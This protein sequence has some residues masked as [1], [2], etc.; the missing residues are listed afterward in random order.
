MKN[1]LTGFKYLPLPMLTAALLLPASADAVEFSISGQLS[2][3]I[4]DVDNGEESGL[5]H[6]DNSVSGTRWR[7]AGKG[8]L[9][10]GMTAG[11]LYENQLQS[12][13]SSEVTAAS[14]DSDGVGGNVGGGDYFSLRFANVWL[15]G[16][17]GKVT[18][19]QGS[20]AADGT[21]EVDQSGTTVIQYVGSSADLLGSMEYGT[22][23]VTVAEARSSYDGLGRNDNIRYDAALGDF[24]FAGS[25]GNG[26]KVEISASYSKDNLQLRAGL[27][28][29]ND[30]GN[31]AS[32]HALS[33]SWINGGGLSLTGSIAGDDSDGNPRNVYFKVGYRKGDSAYGF[34]WSETRDRAAGDA[35]SFSLAW[36]LDVMQGIQTYASYRVESL[37]DVPGEDNVSALVGGARV[38]F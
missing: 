26:D 28:D 15:Q 12:N 32:G 31:E 10:N 20:G 2:R 29:A 13:P 23:G 34:D 18:L 36:V 17:F 11:L 21:A 38:K 14:L 16:D 1:K 22:S 5:V 27:W 4:M 35:S 19:G 6:A 37:D 33:A 24:A 3:L 9:D 30:S 25:L 7:I 8:Q